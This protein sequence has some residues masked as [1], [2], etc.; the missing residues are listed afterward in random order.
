MIELDNRTTLT[1]D[2]SLLQAISDTLTNKEIE[3][4][5][6]SNSEIQSINSV[7]LLHIVVNFSTSLLKA[8]KYHELVIVTYLYVVSRK[9]FIKDR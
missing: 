2:I 6:T 3:L 1:I 9:S 8:A 4:I 5:V 7:T